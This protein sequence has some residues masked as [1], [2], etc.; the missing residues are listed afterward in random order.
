MATVINHGAP[1][2][3]KTSSALWYEV[4]EALRAGRL[5]ITNIEGMKPLEIIEQELDEAFPSSAKLWRVSTQNDI[6]LDLIRHFYCWAPIGALILIDEVQGVYPSSKVDKG[7]KIESLGF[8][9]PSSFEHLPPEF[10]KEY[11]SRLEDIKP[12]NLEH[13]DTDDLGQA[14]FDDN[15]HIIY[16]NSLSDAFNRHRKYNWDIYTCTPD[17]SEV[18]GLVRGVAEIAHS[19]KSND[20]IGA[21]IKYY[22][23]RPRIFPHKPLLTGTTISKQDLVFYRKVPVEVHKL[24][25]STATGKHNDQSKGRTPFRDPKIMGSFIVFILCLAYLSWFFVD[26]FSDKS[27]EKTV[28][29]EGVEASSSTAAKAVD[30]VSN[31]SAAAKAGQAAGSGAVIV[32]LPYNSTGIYVSAVL[33]VYNQNRFLIDRQF[34]FNLDKGDKQYS[35]T[36]TELEAFGFGIEYKGD[37]LVLIKTADRTIPALCPPQPISEQVLP[38][39]VNSPTVEL[40]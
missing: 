21:V 11:I 10:Y 15:G 3:Y 18:H 39:A 16:P 17:I 26:M 27:P 12:E 7:F 2:S 29:V 23:R 20:A 28:V 33:D 36:G 32:G 25:K 1:G 13:G 22:A 4:L 37:C 14:L 38:R 30:T 34:V 40:F 24:Y 5:V 31:H 35:I 19:Y 8:R 6:G 9:E